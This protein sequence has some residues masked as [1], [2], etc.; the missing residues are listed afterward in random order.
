MNIK[1]ICMTG[2]C[3]LTKLH[4]RYIINQIFYSCSSVER[5]TLTELVML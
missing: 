5:G 2:T 3:S 4:V 1:F